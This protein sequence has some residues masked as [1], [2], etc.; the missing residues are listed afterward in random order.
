M[1]GKMANRVEDDIADVL[2]SMKRQ[3]EQRRLARAAAAQSLLQKSSQRDDMGAPPREAAAF[4]AGPSNRRFGGREEGNQRLAPLAG[5]APADLGGLSNPN[6][7]AGL[8]ALTH[9]RTAPFAR[10]MDDRNRS[11]Q[12]RFI[13]GLSELAASRVAPFTM[14]DRSQSSQTPFNRDRGEAPAL[15]PVGW[16]PA[17]WRADARPAPL[18]A[19][20]TQ[21]S[22]QDT[23]P[24]SARLLQPARLQQVDPI[25]PRMDP[26]TG[27]ASTLQ[28]SRRLREA[29]P[30][31][32]EA[33]EARPATRAP[34]DHFSTRAAESVVDY[35]RAH[36]SAMRGT[37]DVLNIPASAIASNIGEELR[38]RNDYSRDRPLDVVDAWGLAQVNGAANPENKYTRGDANAYLESLYERVRPTIEAGGHVQGPVLGRINDPVRLDIGVANINFATAMHLVKRYISNSAYRDDPLNLRRYEGHYDQ[39]YRDLLD[40]RSDASVR[41]VGLKIADIRDFYLNGSG[42][43]PSRDGDEARLDELRQQYMNSSGQSRDRLLNAGYRASYGAIVR[44][45]PLEIVR[46]DYYNYFTDP[47]SPY[48]RTRRILMGTDNGE[49]SE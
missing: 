28:G 15:L 4:G 32:A 43:R 30:G 17:G 35:T 36:R 47:R 24:G 34:A 41:I 1:E 27:T 49:D 11:L 42:Y 20:S 16:S 45:E 5:R 22:R 23:P 29:M 21:S 44:G 18:R 7:I 8:G 19:M 14:E 38:T 6:V 25:G 2:A 13:P 12:S 10:S 31:V 40:P 9:G 37:A 33:M 39:L 26:G 46:E 3:E 48:H